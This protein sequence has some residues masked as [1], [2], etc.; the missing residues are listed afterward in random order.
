M[1]DRLL[2]GKTE[3]NVKT[4]EE[5][6]SAYPSLVPSP[7][8]EWMIRTLACL[9]QNVHLELGKDHILSQWLVSLRAYSLPLYFA[10]LSLSFLA[11]R[12]EFLYVQPINL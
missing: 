3:R 6:V 5:P 10:H 9:V 11:Q 1:L 2:W 12:E 4:Q 8:L 7:R